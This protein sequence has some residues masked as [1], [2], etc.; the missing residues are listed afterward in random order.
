[1]AEQKP[2]ARFSVTRLGS[3]WLCQDCQTGASETVRDD[4]PECQSVL[5]KYGH[6][7]PVKPKT[8][9]KESG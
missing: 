3:V 8:K 2:A 5:A 6:G 9:K 1:M 7:E 4:D